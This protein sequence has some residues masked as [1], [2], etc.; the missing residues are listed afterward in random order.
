MASDVHVIHDFLTGRWTQWRGKAFSLND[1]RQKEESAM[2]AKSV[3]F[4]LIGALLLTATTPVESASGLLSGAALERPSRA[5]V[6]CHQP[7]MIRDSLPPQA[8]SATT[9]YQLVV[10][11]NS[12]LSI[13]VDIASGQLQFYFGG[14][15]T[16][17]P[18]SLSLPGTPGNSTT[19]IYY[20][21]LRL[22]QGVYYVAIVPTG[23]AKAI[24]TLDLQLDPIQT[25]PYSEPYSDVGTSW[26][27]IAGTSGASSSDDSSS[28]G[29]TG[30]Q[31]VTIAYTL[32]PKKGARLILPLDVRETDLYVSTTITWTNTPP[33]VLSLAL[34]SIDDPVNHPETQTIVDRAV[35]RG[36]EKG[37]ATLSVRS[38]YVKKDARQWLIEVVNESGSSAAINYISVNPS[39]MPVHTTCKIGRPDV[40]QRWTKYPACQLFPGDTVTIVDV[41]GCVNIGGATKLYTGPEDNNCRPVKA[42]YGTLAIPGTIEENDPSYPLFPQGLPITVFKTS[43]KSVVIKN[44]NPTPVLELGYVDSNYSDNSYGGMNDGSC[45]QCKGAGEAYVVIG[46]THTVTNIPVGDVNIVAAH[47]GNCL[48]VDASSGGGQQDGANVQ[49]WKCLGAQQTNQLW[50]IV[51]VGRYYQIVAAHSGKCL[52]VAGERQ[53]NGAN[54]QQWECLGVKQPNQLWSIVPLGN[55]Y[56]IVAAHSSKCLDVAGEGQKNGANVQ[57]WECL[58]AKQP[59]PLWSIRSLPS[60]VPAKVSPSPNPSLVAPSPTPKPSAT[61]AQCKGALVSRV[62]VGQKVRVT[63]DGLPL[64]VH[65]LAGVSAPQIALLAGKTVV[66]IIGGP[67]CIDQK[68]WWNIKLD[69]GTVGWS[70]E[71]DSSNYYLE[72]WNK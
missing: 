52:D 15:L 30:G 65:A 24:F 18:Y 6:N 43:V 57:Q 5:G 13:Q 58:G 10:K 71:G 8:I 63:S 62:A 40:T 50:R 67:Q 46:I 35:S 54:V 28:V 39:F 48:D 29:S 51:P 47:S 9:C 55:D 32:A 27:F 72:P 53:A 61:P 60:I 1:R 42:L 41:G 49:Q 19:P 20:D 17:P 31:S 44:Q 70:A 33:T 68:I 56:Q 14:P 38:G 12:G 7:I 34:I 36:T 69:N 4:L 59:N 37:P 23:G 11:G 45:G 16:D 66:T 26:V 2:S 64:R 22:T 21:R 25:S 3:R